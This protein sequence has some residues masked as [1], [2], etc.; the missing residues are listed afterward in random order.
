[1]KISKLLSTEQKVKALSHVLSHPNEEIRVRKIAASLHLSPSF[2]SNLLV[3]LRKNQI[4]RNSKVA[5]ANPQARVLK[6]FLNISTLSELLPAMK[7]AVNFR[8]MGL[9]G[10]WANG[11]NMETSDVDLWLKMDKIPTIEQQARLSRLVREKLGAEPSIIYLTPEMLRELNGKD[12]VFYSSLRNSF[13]L[14]G[15]FID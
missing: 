6:M 1:M 4:L 8:G 11:T 7:K 3:M 9:Y 10:S 12:P 2:V 5:L 15:E 14:E 13:L